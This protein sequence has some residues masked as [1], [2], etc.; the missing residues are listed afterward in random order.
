MTW[1]L[2]SRRDELP[3]YDEALLRRELELFPEWYVGR[4]LG[5]TLSPAERET[6]ERAFALIVGAN[7]AQPQ[8]YVHRDYMPRNLMVSEPDP[9]ILDF[10]DAVYGPITY[11]VACLRGR[12]HELG[13]RSRARL[14]DPLLGEGPAS[15]PAGRCGLRRVLARLRMDGAAAALEGGGHL[16]AARVPRRQAAVPRGHAALPRLHAAGARALPR[17]RAAR[18]AL[19]E[20]RGARAAAGST[21]RSAT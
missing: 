3:L 1:Q 10:Q 19:R 13:G 12:V 11:D 7:L 9:G 14:D 17:A 21:S 2:A 5:V 15:G 18:S 8:V 6:I 16:R 20:A 4:H